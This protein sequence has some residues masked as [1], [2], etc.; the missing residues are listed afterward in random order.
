M[1]A[2]VYPQPPN[3]NAPAQLYTHLIDLRL[4]RCHV[5]IVVEVGIELG[6]FDQVGWRSGAVQSVVDLGCTR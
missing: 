6:Q 2:H 5:T 4:F 3:P 1:D